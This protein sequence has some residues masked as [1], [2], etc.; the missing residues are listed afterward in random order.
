M[1]NYV[2]LFNDCHDLIRNNDGLTGLE[3]FDEMIKVLFLDSDNIKVS[4]NTLQQIK[5]IFSQ[6]DLSQDI[7]GVIFESFLGRTF[8][9]NLGQFFTPREVVEF[10]CSVVKTFINSETPRILD[11]ACGTGG[12]LVEATKHFPNATFI[13][14]D[15][16]ERVSEIC[17]KNLFLNHSTNYEV[18]FESFLTLETPEVDLVITN[19]PFGVE[20]S[21][22][23]IL[24]GYKLAAG[25]KRVDLEI[26]FLEKIL[27]ILK[28]GGICGVVLPRG[29]LNNTSLSYVR[30]FVRNNF[31][32]LG[33]LDLPENT[34]KATGTGCETSILF[35]RKEKNK[36]HKYFVALP[37]EIGFETKTKNAEK[38]ERNDLFQ[39]R[40]AI[41]NHQENQFT[42]FFEPS[43]LIDRIDSSYYF[44]LRQ[45]S[46]LT[47]KLGDY[48][49]ISNRKVEKSI[50]EFK[51]IEFSCVNSDF[52]D[53]FSS[54][55]INS[56]DAPSR[57]K[58]LLKDGDIIC[59]R[60][61]NSTRS[62]ASVET[63]ELMVASTGFSILTPNKNISQPLL[64]QILKDQNVQR[65]MRLL[66]TGTIMSSYSDLDLLSIRIDAIDLD[67]LSTK[68]IELEKYALIKREMKNFY[69]DFK[70]FDN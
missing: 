8:T 57:A 61:K 48:A 64:V 39:I 45:Y 3:A 51:Y 11:P 22:K 2:K 68:I 24:A 46:Q 4:P 70:L 1:N 6:I 16:N 36:Q 29:L 49:T 32:I 54:E 62:I 21:R 31:S 69:K 47:N 10:I 14:C 58:R 56:E 43:E 40:E 5:V 25:K 20:E 50:T 37:E 13:G 34:F 67:V 28:E 63:E 23:D 65:Q 55:L 7:A 18:Y 42:L 15:I 53:I 33:T 27:T 60:L 17:K 44:W 12:F 59:A 19:P 30:D 41:T 9:G 38:I 35:L 52:N 26:L 66:C